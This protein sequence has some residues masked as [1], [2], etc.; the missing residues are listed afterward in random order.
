MSA[1]CEGLLD[2]LIN[3]S[4]LEHGQAALSPIGG[5]DDQQ[6]GLF[7]EWVNGHLAQ[8]GKVIKDLYKDL[9]DGAN[10]LLF[11]ESVSGDPISMEKKGGNQLRIHD[12]SNVQRAIDYLKH[13]GVKLV[14]IQ[15]DAIVNGNEKTT[16]ALVWAIILHFHNG[17][18]GRESMQTKLHEKDRALQTGEDDQSKA[19]DV[20]QRCA[21]QTQEL[22]HTVEDSLFQL[23]KLKVSGEFSLVPNYTC[24]MHC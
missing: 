12:V 17:K 19:K 1:S 10:L 8:K 15:A 6:K 9:Q 4:I 23:E 5:W 18:K 3:Q 16:L 7:T 24:T 22:I 20:L 11:L 13:K 2:E 21:E 14:N